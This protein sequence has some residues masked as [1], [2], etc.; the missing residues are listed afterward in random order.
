VTSLFFDLD[1]TL[2]DPREGIVRS[3]AHALAT[4]ERPI[5]TDGVLER[6]IGPP[7]ARTFETLLETRDEALIRAAIEAYRR[8][9]ASIG[10][11]ENRVYPEVPSALSTLTARAFTL[12]LVTSKPNVFA[13]RILDHFRLS[14]HFTGIHGPDLDDMRSGKATLVGRALAVERLAP[15]AAVMIGD[16]GEDVEG[17]RA[18]GVRSIGVTWGY[19]SRAE[20]E[21]AGADEIVSSVTELLASLGDA[22]HP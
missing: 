14:T 16:R 22:G 3:I 18:N 5:P 4:L 12:H 9:F 1:G 2:T 15:G 6:F 11:F 17:A 19:G 7:L 20:L 8:R 10:I 21:A 13:H